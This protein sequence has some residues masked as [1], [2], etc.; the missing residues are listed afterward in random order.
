MF[1]LPVVAGCV[2]SIGTLGM[3]VLAQEEAD[4]RASSMLLFFVTLQGSPQWSLASCSSSMLLKGQVVKSHCKK[5][6][7]GG[8]TGRTPTQQDGAAVC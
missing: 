4:A 3:V 8:Y 5:T 7:F 1:E 2:R 6:M